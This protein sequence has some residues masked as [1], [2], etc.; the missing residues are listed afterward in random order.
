MKLAEAARRLN[1]SRR[2][3]LPAL[4]FLTDRRRVADPLAVARSLPEGS[5]VILRDYDDPDRAALAAAL[6]RTASERELVLLVGSDPMLAQEVG[7]GGVHYREADIARSA[8]HDAGTGAG[9]G[10]KRKLL[11][12]AA[13][14]SGQA[15]DRAEAAGADVAL[16]SPVFPTASHPGAAALGIE[17]FA[18]LAAASPLP[19]YALGGIT[20]ANVHELL[21]TEAIGIGAI[22]ALATDSG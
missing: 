6:A 11:I 20:E 8:P 17:R 4:I 18:R 19:V 14:H 7:A 10:G 21:L 12:S 3:D 5:V 1:S 22:S 13:A 2:P 16:L 15:L 9:V